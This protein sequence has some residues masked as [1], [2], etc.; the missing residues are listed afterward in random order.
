M[1]GHQE[2][3]QP[4][5][6]EQQQRSKPSEPEKDEEKSAV[7]SPSP[8]RPSADIQLSSTSSDPLS[9]RKAVA[10][11]LRNLELANQRLNKEKSQLEHQLMHVLERL[12][13]GQISGISDQEQKMTKKEAREFITGLIGGPLTGS[14]VERDS[15]VLSSA[16]PI[17]EPDTLGLRDSLVESNSPVSVFDYSSLSDAYEELCLAKDPAATM[18]QSESSN[19][20]SKGEP[21][22]SASPIRMTASEEPPVSVDEKDMRVSLVGF[23]KRKPSG[24]FS[25]SKQQAEKMR[26]A[27]KRYEAPATSKTEVSHILTDVEKSTKCGVQATS[28]QLSFVPDS[29]LY[30]ELEDFPP[31]DD[32]I[33]VPVWLSR[34]SQNSSLSLMNVSAKFCA[35]DTESIQS[36]S[37][38]CS[39][40]SSSTSSRS[41]SPIVP[42]LPS[43]IKQVHPNGKA[44]LSSS[45]P[46]SP[47]WPIKIHR[48]ES[49]A[50]ES[51]VKFSASVTSPLVST[52]CPRIGTH[53][54]LRLLQSTDGQIPT[55]Q[56]LI[57]SMRQMYGLPLDA[58]AQEH[59]TA[60]RRL[61]KRSTSE[62]TPVTDTGRMTSAGPPKVR[63]SRRHI[64]QPVTLEESS[65]TTSTT[66]RTNHMEFTG[67]RRVPK[68]SHL[69]EGA[70]ITP[71]L[72]DLASASSS[73]MRARGIP[74][75]SISRTG[76]PELY[77]PQPKWK[78]TQLGRS[79]DFL[80]MFAEFGQQL[81]ENANSLL[82]RSDSKVL[83]FISK[84]INGLDAYTCSQGHAVLLQRVQPPFRS[85]TPILISDEVIC[86]SHESSELTSELSSNARRPQ[87]SD[88]FPGPS[89]KSQSKSSDPV[90]LQNSPQ[91]T[92]A[93]TKDL[94]KTCPQASTSR[95][96]ETQES[97]Q[98]PND[99]IIMHQGLLFRLSNGVKIWRRYWAVLNPSNVLLHSHQH[100]SIQLPKRCILLSEIQSI[101]KP[102]VL[103]ASI[104]TGIG[105]SSEL[106]DQERFGV[107]ATYRNGSVPVTRKLAQLHQESLGR[108]NYGHFEI[109]LKSGKTHRLRGSNSEETELWM[110]H[111]KRMLRA[112]RARE[113]VHNHE[114]QLVM[115]TWLQRVKGGEVSWV[116]CRLMGYYLVYAQDPD[117]L[118]PTGFKSLEGTQIKTLNTMYSHPLLDRSIEF[119]R[120]HGRAEE[121]SHPAVHSDIPTTLSSSS[122]SDTLA[123][124]D[125]DIRNRTI[126]LW[127]DRSDPVYLICRTVDEFKQWRDNLVRACHQVNVTAIDRPVD[128]VDAQ[129]RL[130]DYWRVLVR[131]PHR[132]DPYHTNELIKHPLSKTTEEKQ[133]DYCVQMFA[134]L[135]FLSY[136]E[137][138]YAQT[139]T[140]MTLSNLLGLSEWLTMK[141]LIVKHLASLC[142]NFPGLKDELF[143]QLIKQ[144]MLSDS[145][146]KRLTRRQF[147][148]SPR[149]VR[150]R[151]PL[152]CA[153]L[154]SADE[155][156]GRR[157]GREISS[158]IKP[159]LPSATSQEFRIPTER[160]AQLGELSSQLTQD[161]RLVFPVPSFLGLIRPEGWWPLV[162]IWEC[163]CLILPL[164]LPS[165]PVLH[166]L[167]LLISIYHDADGSVRES[168]SNGGLGTELARYAAFCKDA[169][170]QTLRFGGRVEVPSALEVASISIRNPYTHSYPFS[171]PI[172]LPS[173][174]VYEVISFNGG[175]EFAY[176]IQQIVHKLG[177]NVGA[178]ENCC[179]FAIYLRLNASRHPPKY[180]YLR[181]N[182]K[183]CDV[184][185]LYEQAVLQLNQE[186]ENQ[187]IRLEDATVELVFRIQAFIWKRLKKMQASQIKSLVNMLAHQLHTDLLS[188]AYQ[189]LPT[190]SELLDLAAYL[191]RVDHHDYTTLQR[192]SEI[193]LSHLIHTYFPEDWLQRL[194]ADSRSFIQLKL[195]LLDRWGWLCQHPA[196]VYEGKT[197]PE[198]KDKSMSST[199]SVYECFSY[200]RALRNLA[201]TRF[202]TTAFAS[203][204]FNLPGHV[205]SHLVWIVPQETQVNLLVSSLTTGQWSGGMHRSR[206]VQDRVQRNLACIKSIP[207]GAVLSFGGQRSGAFFLVY[208][209]RSS[210][211]KRGTKLHTAV[212]DTNSTS[213]RDAFVIANHV[214]RHDRVPRS[215]R[216]KGDMWVRKLRIHLTDLNAV[217]EL[218]DTLVYFMNVT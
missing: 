60:S 195:L 23:P 63:I 93:I 133:S 189:V 180:I 145:Q 203:H 140:R 101:R 166:C 72:F 117:S 159:S 184:I 24:I 202:G 7:D 69:R 22:E 37:R 118:A 97:R 52:E 88:L 38:S 104:T 89:H 84:L 8:S 132:S 17:A 156:S 211:A 81:P 119:R 128:P 137:L 27:Q 214:T 122:D 216:T 87:N 102:H 5:Q 193:D 134:S 113:V 199:S 172:Y 61:P 62:R 139:T 98:V 218:T 50:R 40:F 100:P 188:G 32:R 154:R 33:K 16:A 151:I 131:L 163:L 11:R 30:K 26:L 196:D 209:D 64:Q 207:Y 185:S 47:L 43:F 108:T 149:T 96:D 13:T 36:S 48:K 14:N 103:S 121:H 54:S 178:Q 130:K 175:S 78:H 2:S 206:S 42:L 167:E 213:N 116:W 44:H 198:V 126:A 194:S 68:P 123:T 127:T 41:S 57:D 80:N 143:L 51:D 181:P 165:P 168:S 147:P 179:L 187:K 174:G 21:V 124:G 215:S 105:A 31:K 141:H 186:G 169:L 114:A 162:A 59:E 34:V 205:E 191:C 148:V 150:P 70:S 208:V 177:L 46:T 90:V 110:R 67:Q 77:S 164:F 99:Q 76:V 1:E 56:E 53:G 153:R 94:T 74:L 155:I 39:M 161:A 83:T 15:R 109:I 55:R 79:T 19:F 92:P 170:T 4:Q 171:I 86:H 152:L 91:K 217:Q 204:V 190:G 58:A 85:I 160:S 28:E 18:V 142:F 49:F 201:S 35:Y 182:W 135:L 107:A 158:P 20:S 144:A 173:G 200:L 138:E 112:V 71:G 157:K 3:Q 66:S 73:K 10:L 197:V 115:Q 45:M 212:G 111:I 120:D 146:T 210:H 125:S 183:M 29:Q 176:V 9:V 106:L 192:Q 82:N 25:T 6:Q 136:P 12:A 129:S 65:D 75:M 95:A